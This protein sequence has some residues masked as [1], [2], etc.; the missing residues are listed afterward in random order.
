MYIYMYIYSAELLEHD[1][2]T[3]SGKLDLLLGSYQIEKH[4]IVVRVFFGLTG[5]KG[6][7]RLPCLKS[8]WS[9]HLQKC[10]Q[11]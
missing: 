5:M 6:Y 10:G 4:F 1:L 9:S 8:C 7:L 2:S 3:I 11:I